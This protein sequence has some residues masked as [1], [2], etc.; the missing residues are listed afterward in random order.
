M[1][2]RLAISCILAVLLLIYAA[3]PGSIASLILPTF[4]IAIMASPLV[5]LLAAVYCYFWFKKEQCIEECDA[6]RI[7]HKIW[8]YLLLATAVVLLLISYVPTRIAVW[9]VQSK[10]QQMAANAETWTNKSELPDVTVG[11][12]ET[13]DYGSDERGGVYFRTLTGPDG[14]GPDLVSY[15]I[16]LKPNKEGSPFGNARYRLTHLFGD[17]YRFEASDDY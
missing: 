5:L 12:F 3:T 11:L 7:Q 13:D 10:L 4:F 8:P 17:W 1:T 16:A 2:L 14:I 6:K 15:G 9:C